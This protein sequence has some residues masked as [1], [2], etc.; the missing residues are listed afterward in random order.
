MAARFDGQLPFLLKVLAAA[1]PLSLQAHPSL[2]Q[3]RAG[4]ARENAAGLPPDAPTRCYRDANHKPELICALTT[5]HALCGFRPVRESLRLLTGLGVDV[6]GLER[7]GLA[8]WFRA[9]MTERRSLTRVVE[10]PGFERECA[11]AR[12]LV[13]AWPGDPGVLGALLL[14]YVV[15][16]PGEALFL[17]A[18]NLHAYVEGT[19]VE[20]MANSD[21][22]LRGGLTPKH[23]DVAELLSVLDFT[24][25]APTVLRGDYAT[26]VEDFRLTRL[27][28]G[29]PQQLPARAQI[30]L[31]TEG[32]AQLGDLTLKQ[33]E[34]VFLGAD[35]QRT[36]SG[37][38][39]VFC[40]SAG[41]S[42]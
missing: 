25:A 23:V 41:L 16:Q 21:N 40:A 28:L 37:H 19:G 15:L 17:S 20:L 31:V 12:R 6:T 35:E 1:Q 24:D 3:A 30:L 8:T 32:E 39:V 34:S 26:P 10:V 29:A 18:G 22:V 27:T 38:G 4:F 33:G 9:V 42:P 13:E 5:F 11:L 2:S 36:L 7:D 14:N